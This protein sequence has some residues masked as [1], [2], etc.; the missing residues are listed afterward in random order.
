MPSKE[1]VHLHLHTQ[2]SLLDGAIKINELPKYAAE[3]GYKAVAITDHGNLFGSFRFYKAMKEAGLKPIIGMEAYITKGSRLKKLG[4]G[5][6]DNYTDNQNHHI[7]LIATNDKGWENL[8]K[9]SSIGYIEGFHYKPRID[10][11]V[12]NEHREGLICLTACLRGL[13]TYYASRG[14]EAEAERW[15]LKLLDIFGR[16]NLYVELQPHRIEEQIEAN[17]ILVKLAKKHNLNCTN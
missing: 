8:M 10:L 17:R 6:E 13:P 12:L 11:E 4:K 14:E 3:L 1:F 16:E 15:L 2:F 5:S 9:L 7:V